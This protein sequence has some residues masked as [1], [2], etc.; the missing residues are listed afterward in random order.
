M[1]TI[2]KGVVSLVFLFGIMCCE[3]GDEE[4]LFT[5]QNLS[6]TSW[7]GTLSN[8]SGVSSVMINFESESSASVSVKNIGNEYPDF[9]RTTYRIEGKYLYF[10]SSLVL[11]R[12]GPWSLV[13]F[14]EKN[15]E[16]KS[17]IVSLSPDEQ[18][19]MSLTRFD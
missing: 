1:K 13:K 11:P 16:L 6:Q 19:E 18:Y 5:P 4:L 3:K 14:T 2:L 15:L 17:I 12:T 9:E 8:T 10:D 7:Q